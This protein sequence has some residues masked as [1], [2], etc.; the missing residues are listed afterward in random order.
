MI[1][2]TQEMRIKQCGI[3]IHSTSDTISIL[4]TFLSIEKPTKRAQILDPA[5]YCSL[6]FDVCI[7]VNNSL[8]TSQTCHF[9]ICNRITYVS[10]IDE[11][12]TFL[13]HRLFKR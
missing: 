5:D 3:E 10:R 12:V 2:Y 11:L 1:E 7:F 8:H 9:R 13:V 6:V 4:V